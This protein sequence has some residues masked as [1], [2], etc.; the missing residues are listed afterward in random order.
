MADVE[1]ELV[2]DEAKAILSV[3]D[4]D[5][6]EFLTVSMKITSIVCK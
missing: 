6:K 3:D 5:N 2:Y 4:V 1:Y